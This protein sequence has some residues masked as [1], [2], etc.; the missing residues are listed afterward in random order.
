MKNKARFIIPVII[1][2]IFTVT[3]S[4]VLSYV[5]GAISKTSLSVATVGNQA[6]S[7]INSLFMVMSTGAAITTAHEIGR[8]DKHAASRTAEHAL[9][10]TPV[11]SILVTGVLLIASKPIMSL[12]MPGA[13]KDFLKEGTQ[14]FNIIALSIPAMA[15]GN[16]IKGVLRATGDSKSAMN[17]TFIGCIV[18]VV[19]VWL[20]TSRLGLG[21]AGS[22]LAT[23]SLRYI[24]CFYILYVMLKN[25]RSLTIERSRVFKLDK[26]QIQLILRNGLP[27]V[28]DAC[29]V[30]TGYVIINS[31]LV[32]LG[33]NESA[34]FNVIN[35]VLLFTGICQDIGSVSAT[36]LV[37]QLTGAGN[38]KG[39]VRTFLRILII[40]ELV[41]FLLCLPTVL[42]PDFCARLFAKDADVIKGSADFMWIMYPYCFVAVGCNVCEPSVRARGYG[43]FAMVETILCVLCLRLP[44]TWLMCIKLRL[45]V[46]GM[47]A[48]NITSLTVRFTLSFIR[49]CKIDRQ[50][51]IAQ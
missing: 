36:V 3:A 17:A 6:M 20:F 42:C 45:G 12:L 50:R 11:L 18:Q 5:T 46:P 14:Y 10:L 51:S 22:A 34:V 47:Y 48:A 7:L 8:E 13:G 2:N 4:L 49:A 37:G 24:S 31:M 30:Q 39:A 1:E 29:A 15:L 28:F 25:N 43:K 21:I 26:S 38:H 27:N 23:L 33:E 35:T 32:S 19:G 40:A 9:F 44:L 41:S 16:T